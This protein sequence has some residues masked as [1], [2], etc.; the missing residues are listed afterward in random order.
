MRISM[1][2]ADDLIEEIA[3]SVGLKRKRKETLKD[4]VRRCYKVADRETRD[5]LV[6]LW[7]DP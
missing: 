5:Y 3:M 6:R 1:L 7:A 4:L 2:P